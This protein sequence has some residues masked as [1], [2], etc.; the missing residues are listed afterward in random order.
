MTDTTP[1]VH[2]LLCPRCG[3]TKFEITNTELVLGGIR[4][5][6][7]C[8]QCGR[9]IRTLEQPIATGS[10]SGKRIATGSNSA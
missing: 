6:R 10:N 5:R 4:R 3:S 7:A 9:R 1:E 8:L 2:G